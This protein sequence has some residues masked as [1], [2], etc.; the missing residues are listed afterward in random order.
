MKFRSRSK[1]LFK[2]VEKLK[3]YSKIDEIPRGQA[4]ENLTKGCLVIEGGAFRGVYNQG[5]LDAFMLNDFNFES[6]IGVSAGALA[7]INY[8]SGQIGR[9]AR[10]NLKYRHDSEYIGIKALRISHSP[11]NLDFILHT[12]N[13]IEELDRERFENSKQRFVA[14]ATNC[15]TGEAEYFE[16]GKCSDILEAVKASASMPYLSP[17]V[18]LDGKPYL[19][20]GCSC[21]IAYQWA[22]D[23]GYEKII[24]IKTR[25]RGFRKTVIEKKYHSVIY[26]NFP[27]F[28]EK[29]ENSNAYYNMQCDEIDRL[30][31][32]KRIFVIAPS[33]P[34][35]VGRLEPNIEKLGGLYWLGYN[36]AMA[37]MESLK[38]YLK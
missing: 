11:L 2:E 3:V 12:N 32:E 29:F 18:D 5:V 15:L 17:M 28:M 7:G 38:E 25:E 1:K 9:S 33:E 24:V 36:D 20:G 16:K 30:E 22:I 26:R 8:V 34:V 19:D 35:R 13:K 31:K 21:K 23:Q 37:D 6:V 27:E 10:I 14:V 4:S